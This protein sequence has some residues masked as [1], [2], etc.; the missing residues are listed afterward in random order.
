L[1]QLAPEA[2]QRVPGDEEAER[3]LLE[4][5]PLALPPGR[6]VPDAVG[7]GSRV[8]VAVRPAEQARLP[9][10]AVALVLLSRLHGAVQGREQRGPPRVERVERAALD[11]ALHHPAVYRAQVDALAEVEEGAEG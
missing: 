11:E 2:L 9:L 5:Q 1:G 8:P 6:D 7:R 3:L 4:G 10:L